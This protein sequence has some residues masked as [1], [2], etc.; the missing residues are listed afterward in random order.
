MMWMYYCN[1]IFLNSLFHLP[2]LYLKYANNLHCKTKQQG[3]G[4]GSQSSN[5]MN[6]R[7]MEDFDYPSRMSKT[8][9]VGSKPPRAPT[10]NSVSVTR[11]SLYDE[12]E[13]EQLDNY[14]SSFYLIK[15]PY[16]YALGRRDPEGY[17]SYVRRRAIRG[18]GKRSYQG[19]FVKKSSFIVF[20][21]W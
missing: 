20:K 1:L 6:K 13:P 16:G 7:K 17:M 4:E 15:T 12:E 3:L 11:R 21:L 10:R 18:P 2:F 9:L 5:E 19:M 8:G 14:L